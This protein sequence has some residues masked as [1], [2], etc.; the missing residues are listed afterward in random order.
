MKTISQK[1]H[2]QIKAAEKIIIIPHQNSDGDTAGSATALYEYLTQLKKPVEIFCATTLTPKL[3][4]LPHSHQ[5]KTDAKVFYDTK[6]DTVIILD[7]GDLRYAGVDKHLRDHQATIINI[8]HH[9]T[10]ENYGHHNLVITTASS[11]AEIVYHFFVEMKIVINQRM[12][13]SL[14][15]GLITDT[16]NF[17][18]SA[19]SARALT[20]AS[21]LVRFGGNLN[22]INNK[23]IKNKTI[24]TLR[25]WGIVLSRLEKND[26]L[27]L[28]YTYITQKD[29]TDNH[30]DDAESDGIANFLNNLD[31]AKISLI[32]KETKN[33]KIK[34][35]FRTTHDGVDVTVLAK[36]FS[37]GGH[38]KAAGFTTDG[39]I[40]D[41]LAKI[42]QR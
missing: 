14:L 26:K 33:G 15:T 32:L 34:G 10:N 1:I 27:D 24:N 13:T 11:T 37:G 20:A 36:K 35:S 17:T 38:K 4:F 40:K 29:L 41:V 2:E 31:E 8:D 25:L 30:V 23:V 22:L 5:I 18:N 7:S 42:L 16:D 9:A 3:N 19:T 12:A 28:A 21:Q 39:T 6:V